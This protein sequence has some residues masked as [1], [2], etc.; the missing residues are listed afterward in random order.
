MSNQQKLQHLWLRAGFGISYPE[1]MGIKDRSPEKA[2]REMLMQSRIFTPVEVTKDNPLA[3]MEAMEISK[4]E[5]QALREESKEQIKAM[6]LQ[7]L[8]R[9]NE[10]QNALRE[11]MTLFWHGHFACVSPNVFFAQNLN[12]TLRK[13]ALGKFS[14]LL[15]AVSKEPAMLQFLNN[16]QN[17]KQSPNENFGREVM[18]LFT[19]GR[20]HYTEDDIKNAARAFTGWGFTDEGDYVFRERFH[21]ADAKTF[22][23][24]TGN[25]NGDEVLNI[26]LAQD[27]CAEF[28]VNKIY[29]Y[30]VNDEADEVQVKKLAAG[31]LKSGYNIEQL[32]EEIFTSD[33]F[34][35]PKNMGMHIKS[36]VELIAVMRKQYNIE[37]SHPETLLYVQKMLGQVLFYP[38][39]VAGW[40]EGR[41]WIDSS[42]LMF[43]MGLAFKI[44]KSAPVNEKPKADGDVNTD[45]LA[46]KKFK[47]IEAKMV[48]E[49]VNAA[50]AKVPDSELVNTL[51][52]YYLQVPL[53]ADA[54][55]LV[56]QK[57]DAL[58]ARDL[59]IQ[60]IAIALASL[61]EYQV[62]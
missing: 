56:S 9:M 16:R 31:F 25:F 29:R 7:W 8:N 20:G 28:I 34:Y 57:A 5:K 1:L 58:A 35:Q 19:L 39:N 46:K 48:W 21:D 17:R 33:F 26:I 24:K 37:L 51:A 38:P 44:Y 2:A 18:E 32:M 10:S 12:N 15:H 47:T 13:H 41:S 22:M 52:A 11:K 42:S 45:F 4:E 60:A 6:N 49:P 36:P 30:F 54:R 14:D 61:P 40:P 50:L 59:K 43:R 23:G 27:R 3:D 53:S 62:S 55:N